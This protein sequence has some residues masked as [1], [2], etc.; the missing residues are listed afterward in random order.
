M[1]KEGEVGEV[2]EEEREGE[3]IEGGRGGRW[4]DCLY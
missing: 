2:V 4:K 1:V 3:V